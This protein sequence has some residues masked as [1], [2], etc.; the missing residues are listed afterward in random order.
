MESDVGIACGA[1]DAWCPLGTSVCSA[2]GHDVS[3]LGQ[4]APPG[5]ESSRSVLS[6]TGFSPGPA[7]PAISRAGSRSRAEDDV[8]EQARNYVCK[9]CSTAVPS[10]HKFCGTCGAAVPPEVVELRT[11]LQHLLR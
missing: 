1:C 9:E 2:C 10:G 3:Y 8:M 11:K 5:V 7:Q 4:T 6:E